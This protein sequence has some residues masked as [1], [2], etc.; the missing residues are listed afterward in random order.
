MWL[1]LA[2]PCSTRT[3][4]FDPGFLNCHSVCDLGYQGKPIYPEIETDSLWEFWVEIH[5]FP[6]SFGEDSA[7]VPSGV[8][9]AQSAV[10]NVWAFL[11]SL[12][13]LCL[14]QSETLYQRGDL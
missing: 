10:M 8:D 14:M 9:Y 7:L 5:L 2:S 3:V 4:K 1:G 12:H 13:A 6:L 11:I